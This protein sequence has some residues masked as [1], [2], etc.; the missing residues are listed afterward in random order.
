[1]SF[2]RWAGGKRLLLKYLKPLVD[3]IDISNNVFIEPFIGGGSL[4]LSGINAK[5]YLIN[6]LNSDLSYCYNLLAKNETFQLLINELNDPKYINDK[7]TYLLMRSK[8]NHLKLNGEQSIERSAL[9]L[10][11]NYT[12][13]NGLYRENKKGEFVGGYGYRDKMRWPQICIEKLTVAHNY[14]KDRNVTVLNDD[15]IK[16]FETIKKGDLV[17]FDPPYIDNICFSSY[18]QKIFDKQAQI[19]LINLCDRLDKIGC[20]IIYSNH[21]TDFIKDSFKAFGSQ[22]KF[23]EIN[24]NRTISCKGSTRKTN[25]K[26]E[27]IISNF[28]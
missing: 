14:L 2:I 28:I 27:I 26:N 12:C 15:Y 10:F 4:F 1:M 17:Y 13:F 21:N 20:F 16:C 23:N 8:F 19:D 9:F 5:S 6:D 18:T 25:D 3:K 7:A 11:I 22:W 24:V